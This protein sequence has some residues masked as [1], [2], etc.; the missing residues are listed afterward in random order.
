MG[1]VL[2]AVLLACR[3]EGDVPASGVDHALAGATTSGTP[4]SVGPEDEGP[5]TPCGDVYEIDVTLHGR[6]IRGDGSP[7]ERAQVWVEERE[8]TIPPASWG[9]GAVIAPNGTF[10]IELDGMTVVDGCWGHAVGYFIVAEDEVGWCEV[11]INFNLWRAQEDGSFVA[12]AL[13]APCVIRP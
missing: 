13:G 9:E 12:S 5:G 4:R 3:F 6:V 2:C 7:A 8:W 10:V 1:A 11:P